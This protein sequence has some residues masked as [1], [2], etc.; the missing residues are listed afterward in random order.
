MSRRR[1]AG[2]GLLAL[3]LVA[4]VFG[5]QNRLYLRVAI[6]QPQLFRE[7]VLD[8]S[9][10]PLPMDL[11]AVPILSFSKTNGYRHHD[12]IAASIQMLDELGEENGWQFFHTE[13][14]AVFTVENLQRFRL[15]LLNHKSGTVWT[16]EQRKALQ[17]Y[18]ENGGTLLAQHAA[19]GDQS[20]DWSWYFE[21]VLKAQFVDHPMTHHIQQATLVVEDRSHPAT[22]HLDT[23]W[24][25][26]DEW[27]NFASSPRNNTQVL[28]S[29]DEAT[30]DPEKSPMGADHPM[31]WWHAVGKGRVFYSALGHTPETYQEKDFRQFISGAIEW[32]LEAPKT[33]S[34]NDE[35]KDQ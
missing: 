34:A 6:E 26:N 33:I 30:Y 13:N 19:G 20:Y 23:A 16:A 18:V 29:I 4:A 9:A 21:Q 2:Y 24:I 32:G 12:S 15:L 25:R 1:I 17:N 11:G 14:G 5:Y 8:Q 31:V 10:P 3:L 22:A 27:Y 35:R 28:I 7:P